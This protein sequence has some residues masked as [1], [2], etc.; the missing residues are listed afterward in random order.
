MIYESCETDAQGWTK[1]L[2]SIDNTY[3]LRCCDCGLV[4]DFEFKVFFRAKRNEKA[5]G[6]SR[7][8]KKK[9]KIALKKEGN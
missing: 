9:F 2:D 3:R 6:A 5:T 7:K 8:N 1:W 4:H